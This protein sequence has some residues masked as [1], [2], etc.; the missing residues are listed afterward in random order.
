VSGRLSS[1]LRSPKPAS[2]SEDLE[3]ESAAT[4]VQ[5]R[6]RGNKARKQQ[7][8]DAGAV[9]AVQARMRGKMSRK[10][11]QAK[12]KAEQKAKK[13]AAAKE[14]AAQS[15]AG[16]VT[17]PGGKPGPKKTGAST[18]KVNDHDAMV[19]AEHA[20]TVMQAG[21]RG[22]IARRS[23]LCQHTATPSAWPGAARAQSDLA[24]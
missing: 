10:A 21:L 6:L 20:T 5:A 12:F 9:T 1:F 19:E 4:V 13:E 16:D 18:P 14:A 17:S 2:S 11:E 22:Y 7:E 3:A 8:A 23:G 24:A 15:P